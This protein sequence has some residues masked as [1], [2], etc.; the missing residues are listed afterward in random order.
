M[1]K[2]WKNGKVFLE[3]EWK[4][5]LSN[6]GFLYG[7]GLFET[8]KLREGNPIFLEEHLTRMLDS[9]HILDIPCSLSRREII[10]GCK[11]IVKENG[12]SDGVLRIY[13]TPSVVF[14]KTDSTVPYKDKKFFRS[15]ISSFKR[16]LSSPLV[17]HKTLNYYENLLAKREALKEGYDEAILLNIKGEISEGA[18]SNFFLIKKGDVFTPPISSG[19]L[20]GITRKKVMEIAQDKGIQVKEKVLIPEDL[21]E[22]D[23]AF[24]TS[25]LM[26]VMPCKEVRDIKNLQSVNSRLN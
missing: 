23:E 21:K 15:I 18:Y 22:A 9:S 17:Y 13:L 24:F 25:A 8:V 12:L 4:S 6:T 19:L 2:I 7:E 5:L 16:N 20:P 1:R 14:I 11:N 3:R 10:E 26:G